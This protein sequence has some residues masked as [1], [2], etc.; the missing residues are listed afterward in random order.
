MQKINSKGELVDMTQDEIA[1]ITES[2]EITVEQEREQASVSRDYLLIK[3]NEFGWFTE[4]ECVAWIGGTLPQDVS[5]LIDTFPENERSKL[6]LSALRQETVPRET[7]LILA[8]MNL[9][10]VTEDQMDSVYGINITEPEGL[11]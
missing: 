3:A 1:E 2:R 6:R 9:R 5:A 8:I 11:N 7:P 4:A 10:G